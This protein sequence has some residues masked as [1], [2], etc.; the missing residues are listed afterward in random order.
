M[1]FRSSAVAALVLALVT[2]DGVL[3]RPGLNKRDSVDDWVNGHDADVQKSREADP[4]YGKPT[5]APAPAYGGYGSY[6]SHQAREFSSSFDFVKVVANDVQHQ[7][8][9]KAPQDHLA[10]LAHLDLPVVLAALAALAVLASL[11]TAR[12]VT[13]QTMVQQFPAMVKPPASSLPLPL[14]RW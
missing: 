12:I 8:L 10:H 1:Q 2:V 13:S 14:P 6:G 7:L 9:Y 5:P 4:G 11:D 3:A